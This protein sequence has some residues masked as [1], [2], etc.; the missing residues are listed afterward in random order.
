VWALLAHRGLPKRKL[1]GLHE[2]GS[3][4]GI[5][6]RWEREHAK[7]IS[8]VHAYLA[9][10]LESSPSFDA[11]YVISRRVP[12]AYVQASRYAQDFLKPRGIVDNMFWFL[13]KTP[14]RFGRVAVARHERQG[15]FTDQEI[16]LGALLLPHLQRAITISN[17]LDAR[18]IERVR[19]TE[20]FDA[21]RCG[22]ILTDEHGAILHANQSAEHMLRDGSFVHG[23]GNILTAKAAPAASE[24]RAALRLR[25]PMRVA[26]GRAGSQFA[27]ANL[28][29]RLSSLTSC[30]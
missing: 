21:L 13:M 4:S 7:H 18:T 24:L 28:T 27:C 1:S 16:E 17:V 6:P 19:M 10:V 3:T 26:W 14:T 12:R 29:C 25:Q 5:E 11:P 30:R 20:A 8:E 22:V 9:G 2:T 23:A 15:V